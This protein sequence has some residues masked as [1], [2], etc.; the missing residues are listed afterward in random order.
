[1]NEVVLKIASDDGGADVLAA[2]LAALAHPARLSILRYLANNDACCCRQVVDQM[3]LA[4][5][6]VSQHLQV[7][8]AAGLVKFRPDRQRSRYSVDRPALADLSQALGRFV[9]TIPSGCCR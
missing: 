2:R 4:Q 6:T 9:D 5:S 3:D 8:V 1:M 7:L